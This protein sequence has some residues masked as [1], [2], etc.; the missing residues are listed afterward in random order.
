M[1]S[2]KNVSTVIEA[3]VK[4]KVTRDELIKLMDHVL[5]D[6]YGCAGCGLNGH[7]FTLKVGD[8]E[9]ERFSKVSKEVMSSNPAVLSLNN[10]SQTN[11][12]TS[13]E[14]SHG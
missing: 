14:L 12:I 6:V 11:I 4:P 2:I 3:V 1:N 7:D 13:R 10:F 5:K 8:P 9:S